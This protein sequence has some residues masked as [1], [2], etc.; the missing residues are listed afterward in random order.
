MKQGYTFYPKDWNTSEAVF[1]LTLEERGFY[2]ELIDLAF[3]SDNKIEIKLSVWARKYASDINTLENILSRLEALK[4]VL[5]DVSNNTLF[6][7][8]CEN[9]LKMIRGGRNGGLKS[10]KD[11]P[12]DKPIS[13]GIDKGI[14]KPIVKQNKSK[15]K[16]KEIYRKF[17]HLSITREEC[18]K[19][20]ELGYSKKI[21]DDTLDAIENYSKNKNYTSLYLT[22][23]QW[24]KRDNPKVEVKDSGR[25][26]IDIM[27]S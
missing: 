21:I 9:R 5:K 22:A 8:S 25:S 7:P 12:I 20:Y 10:R 14:D 6:I 23:R 18:N 1:E 3:M 26:L 11:K 13:K 17:K 2:R 27:K 19:L 24:L 16:E 4:L 15:I